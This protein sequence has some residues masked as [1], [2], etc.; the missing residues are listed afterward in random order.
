MKRYNKL[1]RDKI[2]EIL[3][4]NNKRHVYHVADP[5]EFEAKLKEKLQEEVSEFLEDPCLE[6][7]ADVQEVVFALLR[8]KGWTL[9]DLNK[10]RERKLSSRGGFEAWYILDTTE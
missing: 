7:L 8:E 10:V 3:T 2:P 5:L 4:E 1:V 6:E 9:A